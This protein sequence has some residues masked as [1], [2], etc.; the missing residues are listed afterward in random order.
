MDDGY[1]GTNFDR[2][3]IQKL[4]EDVQAG[5]IGTV[6]VKD[7]SRFG[8]N[9]L[10]VG[11]Y[12]EVMFAEY[13]VRFISVLD[14]VDTVNGE[15]EIA[16]FKNILNEMY[17][18]DISRKQRASVQ[19][20]GSSGKRLTTN[21][22]IGYTKD[23][24]GDWVIDEPK[25]A[26]VRRIYQLYLDGASLNGIALLLNSEQV[27]TARGNAVWSASQIKRILTCPEYCGDT[28]NF[29]IRR[30][31]F[32]NKKQYKLDESER[33]VFQNTQPAIIDR[34]LWQLV[35]DKLARI[36]RT[37]TKVKHDPAVFSGFLYCGECG[38]KCYVRQ[39]SKHIALHY[40]CGGYSK[41]QT[42]CTT[43]Y[44]PDHVLRR[45]VLNAIRSLLDEFRKDEQAFITRLQGFRQ[46]SWQNEI[47]DKQSTVDRL[48]TEIFDLEKKLRTAYEDKLSGCIDCDAF[49]ILS[50]HYIKERNALLD[51]SNQLQQEI[52][53]LQ[54]STVQIQSFVDVLRKYRDLDVTEVTQLLLL[55]FVDKIFVHDASHREQATLK[56]IDI[57]FRAVGCFDIFT[58]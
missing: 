35:Q 47:S 32:K 58:K 22:P 57:Y 12:T 17:A 55:D 4:F 52:T 24:D 36:Q 41:Q 43:H 37:V 3:Q 50:N 26:L 54:N 44:M 49:Q 11:Y 18:K 51:I 42:H 6:I 2:P 45:R 48:N 25:A 29:K 13:G 38:S 28:V 10:M 20:R 56:K 23:A 31:S 30:I 53:A 1:T 27:P 21:P 16:A 7:L 34:R 46:E 39:P 40:I 8:R 19:A 9:H 33:R 5:K 14:N 15:N